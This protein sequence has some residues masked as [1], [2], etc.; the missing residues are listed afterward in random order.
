MKRV[1]T[2]SLL[3]YL[4]ID[5]SCQKKTLM[6]Y[7]PERTSDTLIN[8]LQ[9]QNH[10]YKRMDKF[11][12]PD[13]IALKYFFNNDI[14]EQN[15]IEEG[16]NVDEN[17]YKTVKFKKKVCPLFLINNNSRT[18][19]CYAIE[20]CIY[21]AFYDI[22]SDSI[23]K[24]FKI[25]D[26]S[27]DMGNIEIHSLVYPSGYIITVDVEDEIHYK[28]NKIDYENQT[29]IPMGN[30]KSNSIGKRMEEMLKDAEMIFGI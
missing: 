7:F 24:S 11:T 21:L 18:I 4:F 30:N 9:E 23:S 15:S 12:L 17:S 8:T 22:N 10:Y 13:K 6:P 19:L 14:N 5:V 3:I 16:Y 1:L 27:D 26:F 29:F 20:S 28:L 25:S 2:I